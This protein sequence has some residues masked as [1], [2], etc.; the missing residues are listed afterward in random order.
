MKEGRKKKFQ[1]DKSLK[2]LTFATDYAE[3]V[4]H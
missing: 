2:H 4:S 1:D 3:V